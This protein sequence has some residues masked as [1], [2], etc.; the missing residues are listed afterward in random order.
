MTIPKS[1]WWRPAAALALLLAVGCAREAEK[2][3]IA[4]IG[5]NVISGAGDAPLRDAVIIVHAGRI[6]QV[7]PREGFAIP[8]TAEKI[9][10]TGRWVIPGLIDGHGHVE[11]WALPT[12]VAAG[13][14][15]VRDMHGRQ[16]SI[17]A[18]REEVSLG[19]LV[20]PRIFSAGAMLDGVPTTYLDA[21][22]VTNATEARRAVDALAVADADYVKIYTR[23]TPELLKP[24]LDEAGTFHLQIAGH[25][26]LIDAVSAARMGVRS[27]EHMSGV[28]EAASTTPERLMA[29]HRAGFFRGWNAFEK[30]WATTDS[31]S[32]TR[33]AGQLA[34][35]K[36]VLVPTLVL[37]ETF[38]RLDDPA[39]LT[40]PDLAHVPREVVE[41]WNVPDLKARAGW[42][43]AELAAFRASR[44]N[45][46]LFVRA[47]RS[48][49][50]KLVAG[51]DA[52][53]QL[54]V[55]GWSLH[56][57]LELLVR[58]GLTPMDAIMAATRNGAQLLGADS[59]GVVAPGKIADLVI[60]TENPLEDIRN[61][62]TVERVMVRGHLYRADSLT[63]GH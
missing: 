30:A 55:P 4:L 36:A 59:L 40:H 56:T 18:L 51:T 23:I 7:V 57:E 46:D 37:H 60:L 33:V 29:E 25:L 2:D 42:G 32:L 38:S 61:T 53:N 24:L 49:G 21:T 28:P 11:R 39:M 22:P 13:V 31:A 17:L 3:R 41:R 54:L 6:E 1:T 9:D 35:Q 15:A 52:A 48:A 47:F 62:R 27:I 19:G 12:Y 16:D 63:T 34:E 8:R 44:A 20:A 45:Q 43:E 14:T 5:V 10:A 58:A 26:G 50:G